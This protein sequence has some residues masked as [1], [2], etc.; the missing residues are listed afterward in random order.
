[1][2]QIE[3][4][5]FATTMYKQG[6]STIGEKPTQMRRSHGW[7]Y[8]E[9]GLK[10]GVSPMFDEN[11]RGA[12]LLRIVQQ[13]AAGATPGQIPAELQ[14]QEDAVASEAEAVEGKNL[15]FLVLKLI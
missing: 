8:S 10:G 2:L 14:V 1:M 3:K 13:R 6:K 9:G 11:K 5:V 4:L 7:N 15:R 12:R